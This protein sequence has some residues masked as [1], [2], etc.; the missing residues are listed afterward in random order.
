MPTYR[1]FST[2]ATGL[3]PATSGVTGRSWRFRAEREWAGISGMS[4]LF[5]TWLAGITGRLRELPPT[6]HGIC[7]GSDVVFSGDAPM[8]GGMRVLRG[9]PPQPGSMII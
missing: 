6:F 7:A 5:T 3:E 8:R 2:G 4:R 1:K 9:T